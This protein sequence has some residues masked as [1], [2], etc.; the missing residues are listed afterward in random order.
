MFV[1]ASITLCYLALAPVCETYTPAGRRQF[2]TFDQC[3]TGGLQ[4]AE[5]LADYSGQPFGM[6]WRADVVCLVPARKPG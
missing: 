2:E 5:V 6:L 3:Q 1:V 4:D